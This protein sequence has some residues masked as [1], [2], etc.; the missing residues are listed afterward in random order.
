MPSTEDFS[1]LQELLEKLPMK[2]SFCRSIVQ[3][4]FARL[5]TLWT[6]LAAGTVE[7]SSRNVSVVLMELFA[8]SVSMDFT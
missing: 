3:G 7:M 1:S 4:L 8:T 5:N 6:L 2:S